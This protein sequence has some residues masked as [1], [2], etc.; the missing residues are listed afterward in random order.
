MAE[1]GVGFPGRHIA[2]GR[3]VHNRVRVRHH[4]LVAHQLKRGHVAGVVTARAVVVNQRGDV[5]G[6]G[7]LTSLSLRQRGRQGDGGQQKQGAETCKHR[8]KEIT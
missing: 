5:F 2:G 7:D 4:V 3:R 1:A 8:R 6:E